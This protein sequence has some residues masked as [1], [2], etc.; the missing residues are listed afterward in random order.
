MHSQTHLHS[1]THTLKTKQT[2]FTSTILL[3]NNYNYDSTGSLIGM[4]QVNCTFRN[5]GGR[6]VTVAWI[7]VAGRQKFYLQIEF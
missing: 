1:H 3:G 6:L 2:E 5:L 7:F 4:N